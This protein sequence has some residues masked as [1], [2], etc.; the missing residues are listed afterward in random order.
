MLKSI[1]RVA[2]PIV[3][4]QSNVAVSLT[5]TTNET[6]LA[7]VPVPGGSMGLNGSIRV[8][9]VWSY[10]N[11]ANAKRNRARLGGIAGALFQDNSNTTTASARL[12]T[13]IAN[14][15]SQSSQVSFVASASGGF[16]S[17][18]GTIPTFAINT[19]VS[20]DL[21]LTGLLVNAGETIT[22]ESYLVELIPF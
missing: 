10:T 13:Q 12:M 9:S 5:G 15:N 18:T 17:S 7:T 8:T 14:R 11:S 21:V 20:Q 3:L 1:A 22:L 16:G 4:A 19:A 6:I 2:S